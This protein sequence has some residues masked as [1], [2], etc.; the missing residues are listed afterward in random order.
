M[1]CA[2]NGSA[3]G[4]PGTVSAKYGQR[5]SVRRPASYEDDGG[6]ELEPSGRDTGPEVS[7]LDA[8]ETVNTMATKATFGGHNAGPTAGAIQL[9]ASEQWSAAF[10]RQGAESFGLTGDVQLPIVAPGH[11]EEDEDDEEFYDDKVTADHLKMLYLVSLYSKAAENDE[12]KEIWIRS[13]ALLVLIYEGIVTGVLD[14]DYSSMAMTVGSSRVWMNVSQEGKD[15]LDDLRGMKLINSIKL[16]TCDHGLVV[17]YQIS[18]KGQKMLKRKLT[19]SSQDAVNSFC[20]TADGD[21]LHVGIEGQE[22]YFY[23]QDREYKVPSK[24]TDTEDV[25]YVSSPYLPE[26]LRRGLRGMTSNAHRAFESAQGKSDIKDEYNEVVSLGDVRLLVAEWVPFGDNAVSSMMDKLGCQD[27]VQGGFFSDVIDSF[28]AE[29][30]LETPSGLTGVRVL[31]FDLLNF[32]NFEADIHFAEDD[33]IVQVENFG[34]HVRSDGFVMYGIKIEAIM[35]HGADNVSLDLMSRLLM[36]IQNDSTRIIDSLVSEYQ[37]SMLDVVFY[38]D[39]ESRDK[40]TIVLSEMINP[41]MKAELYLDS[42]EHE[43]EI[44]QVIGDTYSA[45]DLSEDDVLIVGKSGLLISGRGCDRFEPIL[46][47]YL[48]MICRERFVRYFYARVF[49]MDESLRKIRHLINNVDED[50][51]SIDAVRKL[52]GEVSRGVILLDECLLYIE[53]SLVHC[54]FAAPGADAALQN[55]ASILNA[56]VMFESLKRRV[57]DLR[58]NVKGASVELVSIQKMTTVITD[59]Q[60]GR[61]QDIMTQNNQKLFDMH[62]HL[63]ES[64]ANVDILKSLLSGLF[65]MELFDRLFVVGHYDLAGSD[66]SSA[67]KILPDVIAPILDIVKG[68]LVIP[69]VGLGMMLLLWYVLGLMWYSRSK[70]RLTMRTAAKLNMI[71]RY[72]FNLPISLKKLQDLMQYKYIE[73]EDVERESGHTIKTIVYNEIDVLKWR[74]QPPRVEMVYDE[75]ARFLLKVAFFL[76]RSETRLTPQVVHDMFLEDLALVCLPPSLPPPPQHH[77]PASPA[78]RGRGR[79]SH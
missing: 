56:G 17:G 2:M 66:G 74:G 69:G 50:P 23:T 40:F 3:D 21:P 30:R 59:T 57:A 42:A 77:V 79:H 39:R 6:H 29:E 70:A 62:R 25:S 26:C 52:M 16:S 31:E 28:P 51:N 34:T 5:S 24:V 41:K 64:M 18:F 73:S 72:T 76:N 8:I 4:L 22:F 32:V 11:E 58:K 67:V 14:Y 65:A 20:F 78:W 1:A 47:S 48:T 7:A 44:K 55:L 10:S 45:H 27:R 68:I 43:S 9:S 75:T 38:G 35:D 12:E 15:D 33:G 60:Q 63:E 46:I 13:H 61:V 19:Q 54:A 49:L 53:E 37:R 36:D 71:L